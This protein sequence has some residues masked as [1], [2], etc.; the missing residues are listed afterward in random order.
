MLRSLRKLPL[1][2]PV[3]HL[4]LF[5]LTGE[6]GR[7]PDEGQQH[8]SQNEITRRQRCKITESC[9]LRLGCGAGTI[10]IVVQCTVYAVIDEMLINRCSGNTQR[11][12]NGA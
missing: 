6:G 1:I 2:R 5:L 7:R 3:G 9:D 8:L 4:L 10:C 11:Q 12:I